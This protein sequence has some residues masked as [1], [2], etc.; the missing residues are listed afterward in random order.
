M[1]FKDTWSDDFTGQALADKRLIEKL[2]SENGR[3]VDYVIEFSRA[4]NNLVGYY[5]FFG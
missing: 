4:I 1:M 2:R 3:W 5:Q